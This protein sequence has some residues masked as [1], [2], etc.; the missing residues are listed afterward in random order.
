VSASMES[1]TVHFWIGGTRHILKGVRGDASF[2]L[3][4]QNL[5]Y[6]E[7]DLVGLYAAPGEETPATPTLTGFKKPIVVTREHTAFSVNAV[8]LVMR[9]FT[10]AMNNQV[11]PRLLVGEESIVIPDGVEA[12]AT[13]VEAVPVST[14]DPYGLA[15]AQTPV[16]VS[17]VHGTA[18]GNIA[19]FAVAAAQVK[20]LSGHENAQNILEWPLE[21]IPLPTAG[22]DQWSLTLT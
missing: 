3:T 15:E 9:E 17:L 21:L 1:V 16:A 10:L 4:A 18:A 5:P 11:E 12:I 19:T 22:N 20:R 7:F 8:G 6:I 13:R 14:F 2:R